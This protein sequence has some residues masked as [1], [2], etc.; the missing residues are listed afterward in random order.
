MHTARIFLF[1]LVGWLSFSVGLP[2]VRGADEKTGDVSNHVQSPSVLEQLTT[3]RSN[4]D[5]IAQ[6]RRQ[7]VE[8]DAD[9]AIAQRLLAD[10]AQLTGGKVDSL[11]ALRAATGTAPT[12]QEKKQ[13]WFTF[14]R[15]LWITGALVVVVALGILFRHYLAALI[16]KIPESAWE[17]FLYAL[18]VG[19]IVGGAYM[20]PSYMLAPVL[21][22]CLGLLGCLSFSKHRHG[23]DLEGWM[24]WLFVPVWGGAAF[25]YHDKVLG[26]LAVTAV[27]WS[28]GFHAGMIPGVVFLGFRDKI[29]I[30]RATVAAGA[31]L[32]VHVGLHCF[33]RSP[34]WLEPFR[35]GL[36]FLGAFVYLLG[37][38]IMSS[39]HYACRGWPSESRRMR[40]TIIQVVTIGS[41][42]AAIYL[43]SVYRV[44]SLLGVGGTF[45]Y[46]YLLEKYFELPWRGIGWAWALLGAGGLLY[47][48]ALFAQAHPEWFFFMQ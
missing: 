18:C 42:I 31:L 7:G 4:L 21:P 5:L 3:V 19:A 36:G 13:G 15:V 27:L 11:A 6:L 46:L 10:A 43:G 39:R 1:V 8:V 38:L 16:R 24:A 28:V 23:F 35:G 29:V 34:A 44:E 45:F 37:L 12:P 17:V 40:Y 2:M 22:G 32:A 14:V 41:G 26:F 30:P 20:P 9:G 25:F 33:G 47:V 48:F